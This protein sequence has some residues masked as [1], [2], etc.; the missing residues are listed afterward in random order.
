MLVENS[1]KAIKQE[2]GGLFT[3]T[4]QLDDA[5]RV[6]TSSISTVQKKKRKQRKERIAKKFKLV[7]FR[8]DLSPCLIHWILLVEL[9]RSKS[10][11]F[12]WFIRVASPKPGAAV[13]ADDDPHNPFGLP[14]NLSSTAA[15]T[16]PP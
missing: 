13:V 8:C 1:V 15:I 16:A 14:T 10:F 5:Y 3:C 12:S 7:S 9:L 6:C 2:K 4:D 11:S